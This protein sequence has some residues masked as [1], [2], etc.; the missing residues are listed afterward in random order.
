MSDKKFKW[1][2][3]YKGELVPSGVFIYTLSYKNCLREEKFKTGSVN[4]L[5]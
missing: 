3:K 2:G 1:D 5:Y 4:V